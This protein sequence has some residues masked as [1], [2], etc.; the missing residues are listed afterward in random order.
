MAPL[1]SA[2]GSFWSSHFLFL[3]LR[4]RKWYKASKEAFSLKKRYIFLDS[5]QFIQKIPLTTSADGIPITKH[6]LKS[7]DT[8]NARKRETR[9]SGKKGKTWKIRTYET[10]T[11]RHEYDSS[12]LKELLKDEGIAF[13]SKAAH[14][15][16][17]R[18][19]SMKVR[20]PVATQPSTEA[21]YDQSILKFKHFFFVNKQLPPCLH[22]SKRWYPMS[23][24]RRVSKHQTQ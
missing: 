16:S 20:L 4:P 21:A 3:Q 2:I 18:P 19:S 10:G 5:G 8:A 1:I 7:K 13:S 24:L 22:M 12:D 11:S 9:G 23:L 14:L 6:L 15:T 17:G